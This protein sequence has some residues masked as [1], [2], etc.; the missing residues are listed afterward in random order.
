M[1]MLVEYL[2]YLAYS[3][4]LDRVGVGVSRPKPRLPGSVG[5][6]VAGAI[7]GFLI[8]LACELTG[9]PWWV[10]LIFLLCGGGVSLLRA[11]LDQRGA[12]FDGQNILHA[13]IPAIIKAGLILLM[14]GATVAAL[15]VWNINP[16]DYAYVPLLPPVLLTAALFGFGHAVLAIVLCTA[17]ADYFFSPPVYDFRITNVEDLVGLS[18]FAGLG[19]CLAWALQQLIPLMREVRRY[20]RLRDG[21]HQP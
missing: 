12:R 8:A 17:V 15:W 4:I 5:L 13:P 21:K 19:A 1:A 11:I 3:I 16:R 9:Y 18:V 10:L 14:I 6:M 7:V 2:P 20:Q